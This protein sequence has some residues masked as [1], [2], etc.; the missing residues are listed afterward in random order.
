VGR[1]LGHL[2]PAHP[3]SRP[4]PLIFFPFF[5]LF[6][7]KHQSRKNS[8]NGWR[9]SKNWPAKL[10]LAG[11]DHIT[12]I[13]GAMSSS[14]SSSASWWSL[15]GRL[16]AGCALH[17]LS[18]LPADDLVRQRAVCRSWSAVASCDT[19]WRPHFLRLFG[20]TRTRLPR[21]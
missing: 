10:L 11:L 15:L 3:I 2:H 1:G 20:P 19:L 8:A 6:S 14:S 21:T 16:D 7:N 17:V 9:A 5:P 4:R 13:A 18:F 12:C